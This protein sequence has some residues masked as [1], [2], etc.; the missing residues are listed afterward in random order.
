MPIPLSRCPHLLAAGLLG[1]A[2]LLLPACQGEAPVSGGAALPD[3]QAAAAELPARTPLEESDFQALTPHDQVVSFLEAL[4][5]GSPRV[6]LRDMGTS[7]AGRRLPYLE[8]SLGT[9]GEPREDRLIL[10]IYAQQHGNEPSGKEGALALALELA[11][12]DHDGLLG[13]VDVILVP[14]VNPDGGEVH[15]R[16]NDNGV[17]LNRSHLALDGPE[18]VALRELFHRWEPEVAVD[19][20]E[21]YPWSGAW[22]SEGWLRLWDVQIGLPTNL[23][24]H[25]GI[26]A[27]AE[28]EGLTRIVGALEDRGFTGHNY[29]VGSPELL[30][31]STT[32]PNDGRQSLALLHTLSF[33]FEGKRSEPLA[34]DMQR[35]S[36]AQRV[37]QETLLRFT[38]ERATEIRRVVH[39]AREE[40]RRGEIGRVVLTMGRERGDGPLEIPVESVTRRDG[41][42]ASASGP[43][44]DAWVVGD[45]VTAVVE[46]WFPAVVERTSTSL[47]AAYLVPAS[48]A[49]ILELLRGHHVELEVVGRDVE[50]GVETLTIAGF[51]QEIL[52]GEQDIARV[53]SRSGRHRTGDGDVLVRTDQLRGVLAAVLLE[54]G[55]MHG[56]LTQPAF[57]HLAA[58]GPY[59][60]LRVPTLDGVALAG[61]P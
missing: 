60:V 13:E 43:P 35:R 34:A 37:A 57:R 40:A 24:T 50:L 58:E 6:T 7:V 46:N 17:D 49:G 48:E 18:V 14:Q 12:G 2:I 31:W 56:A 20:H 45:T 54:P 42:E 28:E 27:L 59:P 38:A 36:E 19:V 4:D 25:P 47:P 41:R 26:R 16:T 29:V 32:N 39:G 51:R 11:R 1:L 30:R 9:F 33:I 3:G 55:S 52:E 23:N 44:E 5:R 15:R 22:L 10:F 8:V 61:I 53:T 21:Y